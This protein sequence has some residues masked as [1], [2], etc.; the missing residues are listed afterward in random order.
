MVDS[1]LHVIVDECP[2]CGK[3]ARHKSTIRAG[4]TKFIFGGRRVGFICQACG[5]NTMEEHQQKMEEIDDTYEPWDGVIYVKDDPELEMAQLNER[6]PVEEAGDDPEPELPQI[7]PQTEE[8]GRKT[9]SALIDEI[10]R[11][12]ERPSRNEPSFFHGARN[13]AQFASTSTPT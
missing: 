12:P 10:M 3:E 11:M 13:I 6:F 9:L 7:T 5:I 8:E 1:T 4:I 2:H